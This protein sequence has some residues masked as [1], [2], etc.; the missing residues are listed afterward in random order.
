MPKKNLI[1]IAAIVA[2]GVATVLLTRTPPR[3]DDPEM[4]RFSPVV[5]SHSTLRRNSYPPPTDAEMLQGAIRGMVES[6]DEHSIYIPPDRVTS[7]RARLEGQEVCTGLLICGEQGSVCEVLGALP[8]SAA[9]EEGVLPGGYIAEIDGNDVMGLG[10]TEVRRLLEPPGRKVVDVTIASDDGAPPK[11]YSLWRRAIEVESVTG[12]QRTDDGRWEY[13]FPEGELLAYIRVGEFLPSTAG[14]I[15]Q[16]MHELPGLRGLVLDLRDNPGG[17]LEAGFAA[18]DLFLEKG[19]VFTQVNASGKKRRFR[20]R[21]TGA[22]SDI[23]LVVLVNDRTASAAEI[24]AGSLQL[25]RRAVLLGARTRGKGLIQSMI[26]LP[27]NMGLANI[28]T[29]E[30]FVGEDVAITRR[31]ERATWGIEPDVPHVLTKSMERLRR[32]HWQSVRVAHQQAA[33]WQDGASTSSS[34]PGSPAATQATALAIDGQLAEA[35]ALLESPERMREILASPSPTM[36][37]DQPAEARD[38]D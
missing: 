36:S 37:A 21:K 22:W 27:D 13:F 35:F 32:K 38:Q 3:P 30:F 5:R 28:T 11:T 17:H 1:W 24:V 31:P 7:F 23:P 4:N 12:L 16:A 2:A 34:P 29:G 8:G 9:H 20:A 6:I 26:A 14:Q 33:Y 15:L 19:V 18:A 25:H 10:P